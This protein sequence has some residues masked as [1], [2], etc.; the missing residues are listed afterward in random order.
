ME[1]VGVCIGYSIRLDFPRLSGVSLASHFEPPGY[2]QNDLV[3]RAILCADVSSQFDS[4]LCLDVFKLW[5]HVQ[6]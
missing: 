6:M 5:T 2:D 4:K 3:K 1:L